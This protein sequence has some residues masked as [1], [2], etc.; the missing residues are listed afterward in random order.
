MAS[1]KP[2]GNWNGRET[3]RDLRDLATLDS[4]LGNLT[5]SL[6]LPVDS[7]ASTTC[8]SAVVSPRLPPGHSVMRCRAVVLRVKCPCLLQ[9][10]RFRMCCATSL[11]GSPRTGECLEAQEW[12]SDD[13][14]LVVGTEDAEALSSRMPFLGL[15]EFDAIVEYGHDFMEIQISCIPANRQVTLHFIIA[16]NRYPE[17]TPVSAW[18]AVDIP[19]R[20]LLSPEQVAAIDPPVQSG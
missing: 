7:S 12:Q 17:P 19:H 1:P 13:R 11:I 5:F 3:M 20:E 6:S 15:G 2:A 16:E 18:L 4:A 10:L 9:S 14:I 8:T